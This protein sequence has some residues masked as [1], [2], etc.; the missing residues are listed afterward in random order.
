[1]R[2]P[3]CT[4]PPIEIDGTALGVNTVSHP[5]PI[6]LK[7]LDKNSVTHKCYKH[8]KLKIGY[9]I[10][11]I[12]FVIHFVIHRPQKFFKK[13][14]KKPPDLSIRGLRW[15]QLAHKEKQRATARLAPMP[16]PSVHSGHRTHNLCKN[17][18]RTHM[19]DHLVHFEPDITSRQE[20]QALDD[21][22]AEEVLSAQYNTAELLDALGIKPDDEV[23]KQNQVVA[24][25]EAFSAMTTT[26][27]DEETKT[28][29]VQLKTPE[30][31]R[32]LTGMLAAYDWEFV[33]MAK[34]LR[35]YTVAKLVEETKSPNA[36]IRLKALGL[37]GKVT[38]VGLFTEKIEVKKTDL[39]E[40]EIDRKLKEK[41][42]KF[43]DVT[44]V[45]PIEDIEIKET[46]ALGDAD[47]D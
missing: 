17:T 26:A 41:L 36:N 33:E 10:L 31:V 45:Q 25:R 8:C 35:G 5:L 18:G 14:R 46:P 6:F 44:D 30:A 11:I 34:E 23:D 43:M 40:D 1:M 19:L 27:T 42:A 37:L 20:Y 32:H 4:H 22:S 39:T 13:F 3:P 16:K 2:T 21:A 47:A 29:L 28:K 12:Q 7:N 9:S 24:A 38:E 15:V